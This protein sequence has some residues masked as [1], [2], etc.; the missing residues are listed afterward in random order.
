MKPAER[1]K[2]RSVIRLRLVRFCCLVGV[3]WVRCQMPSMPKQQEIAYGYSD[4]GAKGGL[5][6]Q[7]NTNSHL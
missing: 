3:M 5:L 2:V 4:S 1:T 6:S 7:K